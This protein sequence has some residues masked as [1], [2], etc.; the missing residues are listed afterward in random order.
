MNFLVLFTLLSEL[1]QALI[2][3]ENV[4]FHMINEITLMRSKWLTTFVIDLK[5]YK[6]FLTKLSNN[7]DK[8]RT[9]A[10]TIDQF[11]EAPSKQ[12]FRSVIAGLRTEI[13]TL[14]KD[15][16]NLV[17]SYIDLHAMHTRIQRSLIPIIG[18]GLSFLFGTA[19]EADLK[20]IHNNIDKLAN[21]QE[22]MAYVIDEN[23]SVINITRVEMSQNRQTLNKIIGSLAGIGYKTW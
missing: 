2:V 3:H 22:E 9:A 11:Y 1:T 5:P 8:A 7:L 10:D 14:Q 23:I 15:L 13:A 6:N 12:D 21:N 16:M 19:T 17:E 4:A 18:K 20:V